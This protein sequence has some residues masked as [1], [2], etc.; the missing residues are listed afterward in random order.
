MDSGSIWRVPVEGRGETFVVD[1]PTPNFWGYWALL[2]E[3]ICFA[4]WEGQNA[5]ALVHYFDFASKLTTRVGHLDAP[6]IVFSPG[7]AMTPDGKS[8]L[9]VKM[10]PTTSDIMLIKNFR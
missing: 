10:K 6:A 2:P 3:G 1:G 7:F 8:I 9:Y 4:T 5:P